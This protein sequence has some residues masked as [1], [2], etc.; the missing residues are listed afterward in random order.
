MFKIL[1]TQRWYGLSDAGMSEALRDR[2]SFLRFSGLSFHSATPDASTI[3]RFR[4][5]LAHKDLYCRL[6]KG[7]NRQ[8][9]AHGLIIKTGAAVDASLVAS[10][11]RPR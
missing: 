4:Q 9:D 8:L 1:L 5:T 10:S 3:C 6:L 7:I 11:R 2:L